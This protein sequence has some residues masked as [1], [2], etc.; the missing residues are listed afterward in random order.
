VLYTRNRPI[1]K[2]YQELITYTVESVGYAGRIWSH[3]DTTGLP[4]FIIQALLILIAPALFAASIY[5]VLGRIIA[6]L[7]GERHSIIQLKWLTKIFVSGDCVSFFVQCMGGGI[8]AAGGLQLLHIGEMII[9][10]GLFIQIFFFGFF[11]LAAVTFHVRILRS[12]TALSSTSSNE[13][14]WRT[15]IGI[16]YLSSGI[17][18][19][20]SIFRIVEYLM[21]NQGFPLQHEYMLYIFDTLLMLAVVSIF[22][23]R[24]PA[25]TLPRSKTLHSGPSS[26][27]EITCDERKG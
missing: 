2:N 17:I 15:N 8:Q 7:D 25:R 26:E 10:A 6:Q 22:I 20:R 16:L 4:E 27:H 12:P 14:P 23:W 3:H 24:H 11:V 13:I 18:L 9:I 19:V 1:T 5:M 21:G